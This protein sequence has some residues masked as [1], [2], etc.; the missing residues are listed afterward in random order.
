MDNIHIGSNKILE[1]KKRSLEVKYFKVLVHY[2][3]ALILTE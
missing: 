3:V 1:W 2:S